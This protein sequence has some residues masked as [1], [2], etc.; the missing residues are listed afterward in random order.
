MCLGAPT[1]RTP[2]LLILRHQPQG[3]RPY[4]FTLSRNFWL[5]YTTLKI[6]FIVFCQSIASPL[7][8][9]QPVFIWSSLHN[10]SCCSHRVCK[11][12]LWWFQIDIMILDIFLQDN[13][14][15]GGVVYYSLQMMTD[16]T[17]FPFTE[18]FF[19]REFFT[20]SI[21]LFIIGLSPF[22]LNINPINRMFLPSPS[23][24]PLAYS[25]LTW[26]STFFLPFSQP[27]ASFLILIHVHELW[28]I[29]ILHMEVLHATSSPL[30][31]QLQFHKKSEA[32]EVCTCSIFRLN[33]FNI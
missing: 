33:G 27:L 1:P 10:S 14:F 9:W 29:L 11:V 19:K 30:I 3:L 2:I 28:T 12:T 18:L 26:P 5:Y 4:S 20:S 16:E 32:L 21:N 31:P 15:N 8:Q 22:F 7:H 6:F 13:H 23:T 25:A 24:S 17:L